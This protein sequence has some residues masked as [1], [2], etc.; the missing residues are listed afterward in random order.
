M[1]RSDERKIIEYPFKELKN[2]AHELPKYSGIIRYE[3][4]LEI[5]NPKLWSAIEFSEV[6]ET[7]QLWINDSD[8]GTVV[9]K[10]YRFSI[11]GKIKKGK[12]QIR[13]E[14]VSNLAYSERD[15]LSTYLPLPLTGIAGAVFVVRK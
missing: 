9:A 3:S 1:R 10:P 8:C 2:L 6:G 12:N 14:V 13:I 15:R 4:E 5:D 7:A 11:D